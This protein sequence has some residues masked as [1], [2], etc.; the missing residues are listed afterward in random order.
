MGRSGQ[1]GQGGGR[2]FGRGGRGR[3]GFNKKN[4]TNSEKE[5][6][7]SKKY[8]FTLLES[9]IDVRV[10]G[11]ETTLKKLYQQ[12]MKDIRRNP[13]DVVDSLKDKKKKIS[14]PARVLTLR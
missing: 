10:S 4:K 8:L 12:L 14:T 7:T 2:G 6:T 9:T 3:G 1:P 13:E 11:Y 5:E